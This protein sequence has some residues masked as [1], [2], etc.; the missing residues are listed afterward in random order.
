MHTPFIRHQHRGQHRASG[1][2]LP[3]LHPLPTSQAAPLRHSPVGDVVHPERAV[4]DLEADHVAVAHIVQLGGALHQVLHISP[5]GA[6]QAVEWSMPCS[7]TRLFTGS[8]QHDSRREPQGRA[9]V[10]WHRS[11]VP[12]PTGSAA[13]A[14]RVCHRCPLPTHPR[15][16]G[17]PGLQILLNPLGIKGGGVQQLQGSKQGSKQG[18][19]VQVW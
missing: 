18:D 7:C 8:R 1:Q 5:C 11:P 15:D 4:E 17:L 6:W 3:P 10:G 14:H 16:A 13:D 12:P 2:L 9:R 19:G